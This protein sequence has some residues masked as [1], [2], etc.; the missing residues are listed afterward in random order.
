MIKPAT[1]TEQASRILMLLDGESIPHRVK[2][3]I[4]AKAIS[5]ACDPIIAELEALADADYLIMAKQIRAV[6]AKY[7]EH[8]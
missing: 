8:A 5:S 2:R 3:D 6:I 4:I 1:P 7:K